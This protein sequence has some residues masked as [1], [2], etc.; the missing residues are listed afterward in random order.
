ME[1]R[2]RLTRR[3]L[4]LVAAMVAVAAT[5]SIG[6]AA[7]GDD[8][9]IQGCVTAAG[10]IDAIDPL[11]QAC[12]ERQSPV[13]WYTKAGADASF[14]AIGGMSADADKLDG[15]DSSAFGRRTIA[16]FIG[17][18]GDVLGGSGGFTVITGPGVGEYR[19]LF[20]AGT[21]SRRQSGLSRSR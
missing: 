14:L 1:F 3:R 6:W 18:G 17:L 20:P 13:E 4:A 2:F 15:R 5:G 9:T 12:K 10:T 16:G 11:T 7:I 8:G 19:V 21:W